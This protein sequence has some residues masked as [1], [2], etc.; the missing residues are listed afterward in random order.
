LTIS[1]HGPAIAAIDHGLVADGSGGLWLQSF[2]ARSPMVEE[3]LHYSG[4]RLSR[5]R[6]PSVAG[7]STFN[8]QMAL[9]PG[10]TSLWAVAGLGP[11]TAGPPE[12]AIFK[13]GA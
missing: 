3:L 2:N 13:R 7:F 11:N 10:T 5:V 4:G 12:G 9:I 8:F 1:G 6:E